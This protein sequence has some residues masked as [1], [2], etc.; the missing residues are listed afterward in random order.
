VHSSIED[1]KRF[2]LGQLPSSEATAIETH[3]LECRTCRK[4]LAGLAAGP[5]GHLVERRSEERVTV[6][7]PAR[8]KALDPLTSIGPSSN[9]Q[10]LNTSSR[11]LRLRV[12]RP[13]FPGAVVQVRFQDRIVLGTVKYCIPSE[14]E[15][16]IGVHLKEDL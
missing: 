11:G 9:G 5:A 10:V 12:P 16:Q 6:D 3:L 14:N 7:S 2:T 8:V 1:L 13:F 15:F 4:A